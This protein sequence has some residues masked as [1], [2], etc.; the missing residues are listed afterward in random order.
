MEFN[1]TAEIKTY[2]LHSSP[3]EI[4]KW[5]EKYK[6][7]T[8]SYYDLVRSKKK[9][10]TSYINEEAKDYK[11]LNE[12]IKK[13]NNLIKLALAKFT[14]DSDLLKDVFNSTKDEGIRCAVLS[15]DGEEF[16]ISHIFGSSVD[17]NDDELLYF[18]NHSTEAEKFSFFSNKAF[19]ENQLEKLY[20]RNRI[21]AKLTDK[22]WC[23]CIHASYNNPAITKSY[24]GRVKESGR[25]FASHDGYASYKS[26]KTIQLLWALLTKVEANDMWFY[27]FNA[28]FENAYY[29][30]QH[31]ESRKDTLRIKRIFDRWKD[32]YEG[33]LLSHLSRSILLASYQKEIGNFIKVYDNKF[34]R[35]AYIQFFNWSNGVD[36]AKFIHDEFKKDPMSLTTFAIGNPNLMSKKFPKMSNALYEIIFLNK[37]KEEEY[38]WD[39]NQMDKDSYEHWF[40]KRKE[41]DPSM[42]FKHK[43]DKEEID[44]EEELF[45]NDEEV[46]KPNE[47]ETYQENIASGSRVTKNHSL[48]ILDEVRNKEVDNKKLWNSLGRL[49]KEKSEVDKYAAETNITLQSRILKNLE[50]LTKLG[51]SIKSLLQFVFFI[52]IVILIILFFK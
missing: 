50:T 26:S 27:C 52:G 44:V 8:W 3:E 32:I 17:F 4:Y 40:K 49:F 35:Q 21:F 23:E 18:I 15:N 19:E 9:D 14:H 12:L 33:H 43:I 48:Q 46:F 34:S 38:G 7:F 22:Q 47:E 36:D 45:M 51:V 10:D 16:R 42:M 20:E 25:R 2:L 30:A 24:E 29:T 37:Y 28:V 1:T 11:F 31:Q 6:D 39:Y 13:D 5:F 41:E